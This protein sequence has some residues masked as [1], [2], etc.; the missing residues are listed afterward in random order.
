MALI[1]ICGLSTPDTLE[2]AL[3]A[4]ADMVGFVFFEKSPRHIGYDLAAQ[5]GAQ[6]SGRARKTALSVDADDARL[7][8]IVAALAPD[9][10]QL[11]GKES[12]ERVAAVKARYGLPL[13]KAIGVSSAADLEGAAVYRGVADWLLL[14]AKPPKD[15]AH[16]G[17]NGVTFDWTLL[18]HLDRTLPFMLSGGLDPANVAEA[19]RISTPDG[20]DVSS[21]V[22]DRPGVKNPDKIR[23]FVERARASFTSSR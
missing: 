19:I 1:K 6:V 11:H 4:G 3:A 8:A 12:P 13:L 20:V 22:E 7:D 17:G 5:L 14:D 2:A 9:G 21:G 18:K 16:P 10:L 23:A 15:A